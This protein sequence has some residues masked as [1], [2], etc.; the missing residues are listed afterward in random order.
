M[1]RLFRQLRKGNLM[2]DKSRKYLLYAIGEILLVV[3]GILIALQVNNWNE[4]RTA[5]L[6]EQIYLQ[7]LTEDLSS[8]SSNYAWTSNALTEKMDALKRLMLI[9]NDDLYYE[10]NETQLLTDLFRGRMLS[11]AHPQV[12]VA[13]FE[14]LKNTGNFKQINDRALRSSMNHYYED[15]QHAYL[16]IDSKRLDPSYG[17]VIDQI[18]PGF[19]I[20]D[21]QVKYEADLVT[22]DEIIRQIQSPAFHEAVI[23]EYNFSL[24]MYDIQQAGLQRSEELLAE[25]RGGLNDQ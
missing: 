24:F 3:I 12:N 25:V 7:R 2:S 17:D 4:N 15:R 19:N 22:M 5:R 10:T 13:T 11:F 21:G 8:D 23:G 18:I 1:F 14:E 6:S 20:V 16:R 9:Y